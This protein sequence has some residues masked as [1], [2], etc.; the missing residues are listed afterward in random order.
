MVGER[1]WCEQVLRVAGLD[2]RVCPVCGPRQSEYGWNMAVLCC[3]CFSWPYPT[4]RTELIMKAAH[5]AGAEIHAQDDP[6]PILQIVDDAGNLV[7]E[8]RKGRHHPVWYFYGEPESSFDKED[9]PILE[10]L[11]VIYPAWWPPEL[12]EEDRSEDVAIQQEL[13]KVFAEID[14][15]GGKVCH[16]CGSRGCSSQ[17]YDPQ[18]CDNQGMHPGRVLRWASDSLQNLREARRKSEEKMLERQEEQKAL[19]D[20]LRLQGFF[21][22]HK[23][24][25]EVP[26]GA[27]VLFS[28]SDGSRSD[29]LQLIIASKLTFGQL[30][31]TVK[32]EGDGST[33]EK[34]GSIIVLSTSYPAKWIGKGGMVAQA[35]GRA[36][37]SFVKVVEKG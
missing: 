25:A 1:N 34:K 8:Y 16:A 17:S 12:A 30:V 32:A 37:G 33:V 7:A 3:R 20:D 13:E 9:Y 18:P 15:L 22:G 23:G 4:A 35:L 19:D 11:R 5:A 24:K 10:G 28:R 27:E 31:E 14:I 2:P 29:P 6:E 26:S 36:M 21:R